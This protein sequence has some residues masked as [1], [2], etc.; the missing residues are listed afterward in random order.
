MQTRKLVIALGCAGAIGA[1]TVTSGFAMQQ[2]FLHT[3]AASS[4]ASGSA[5]A[6][7][8]SGG[9]TGDGLGL[10]RVSTLS[11]VAVPTTQ[12]QGDKGTV[13]VVDS[14]HGLTIHASG[15]LPGDSGPRLHSAA[16][17]A[18]K[19]TGTGDL[20]ILMTVPVTVNQDTLDSVS[21][22]PVDSASAGSVQ[23]S[24]GSV[25]VIA[26]SAS[27]IDGNFH[28]GTPLPTASISCSISATPHC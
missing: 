16:S 6:V 2:A 1:L 25:S 22:N 11:P 21:L 7:S 9:A 28:V 24:G 18:G 26:P 3:G 20:G 15:T 12:L 19:A 27:V 23:M 13:D 4:G 14:T 10:P 8:A 17:A 5:P